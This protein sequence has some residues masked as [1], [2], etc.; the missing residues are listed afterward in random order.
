MGEWLKKKFET[1]CGLFRTLMANIIYLKAWQVKKH[2]ILT[3]L[4]NQIFAL[5]IQK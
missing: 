3:V 1:L 4:I 2:Q 5:F